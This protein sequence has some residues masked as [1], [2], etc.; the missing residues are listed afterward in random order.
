MINSNY[1]KLTILFTLLAMTVAPVSAVFAAP[2]AQDAR[3]QCENNKKLLKNLF[4]KVVEPQ[5]FNE[6]EVRQYFASNHMHHINGKE[7]LDVGQLVSHIKALKDA[8]KSIKVKIIS[9]TAEKERVAVNYELNYVKNDGN[10]V[11]IKIIGV[12]KVK[13]GKIYE[14]DEVGALLKGSPEDA[15]LLS[16]HQH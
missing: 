11:V 9:M 7:H 3:N 15:E 4:S 13:D 6:K 12:F 10:K 16:K 5:T 2:K 14:C 8:T 1:K